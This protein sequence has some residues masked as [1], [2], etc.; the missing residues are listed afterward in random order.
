MLNNTLHQVVT[1]HLPVNHHRQNLEEVYNYPYRLIDQVSSIS[2]SL[3]ELTLETNID[4]DLSLYRRR[5]T[6]I[7]H[8]Q[9][10]HGIKHTPQQPPNSLYP[11]MTHHPP[12]WPPPR[13]IS[14]AATQV[15]I[16]HSQDY[17]PSV[18]CQA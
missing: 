2:P 11:T 18:P 15:G 3:F 6:V 4:Q 17:P 14:Q 1:L 9:G 13:E 7:D 16:V 10:H 8:H 12:H 5:G